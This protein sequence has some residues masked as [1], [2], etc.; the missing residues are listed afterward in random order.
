MDLDVTFLDLL[1][2]EAIEAGLCMLTCERTCF[3]RTCFRT[4]LA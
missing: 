4:Q 2:V 3:Y 1:P